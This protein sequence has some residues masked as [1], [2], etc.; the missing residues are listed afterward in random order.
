MTTDL[1]HQRP[2]ID[3]FLRKRPRRL[4]S[5]SFINIFAWKDFF[6]FTFETIDNNLCIFAHHE[7]GCF[8]Y[9]PPLGEKISGRA[10][11]ESFRKMNALNKTKGVS[12]IENVE[13]GQLGVFGNGGFSHFKKS[14][15]YVY[16]RGDIALLKG[17]RFKAKKAA[18]HYF[19]KNYRHAY[20]PFQKGM[21][22]SCEMLYH[23]WAQERAHKYND[24]VYRQMLEDNRI[25][26]KN[27]F[28]H[29][30][31]L[32]LIARVVE[33][34]GAIAAYS[35]GFALNDEVFC[36]LFEVADLSIKGLSV[37]IFKEFC[38]DGHLRGFQK[39]NVMDDFGLENIK[40]TKLSFR[41]WQIIPSYVVAQKF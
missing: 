10:V 32:G 25:V 39:I 11:S 3:A 9:L 5:F 38:A 28:T 8:L 21:V 15:E 35:F 36:V 17:N 41:P 22:E 37:Y 23:R 12:R 31:E 27:I 13:E 7:V 33:V 1:L 19:V 4:S 16:D 18:Y 29:Y 26:H 6:D 20:L 34:G 2:A 30:N 40:K 14:D 24:L